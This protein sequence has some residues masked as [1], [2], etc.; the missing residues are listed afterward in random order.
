ME[1]PSILDMLGGGGSLRYIPQL[2][3]LVIFLS[4]AA[5]VFWRFY[6][7]QYGPPLI[8]AAGL[9]L[10]V[11]FYLADAIGGVAVTTITLWVY[12]KVRTSM[13]R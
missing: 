9:G 3:K 12:V 1:T 8:T 11:T 10:V 7:T 5:G 6:R 13:R 2:F 4:I